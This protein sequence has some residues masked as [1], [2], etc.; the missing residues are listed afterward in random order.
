MHLP[1]FVLLLA[2]PLSCLA[3]AWP[4]KTVRFVVPSS[5]GASTDFT[6]RLI[7][8]RVSS[9]WKQQVV[10]EN[11]AG[12]NFIVGTDYVSKQ[13]PDGYTLLFSTMGGTALNPAIFPN[14]PYKF[15][16]LI[17]V[18][19]AAKNNMVLYVNHA[20]PAKNARE[21]LAALK[22][23][24]GKYNHASGGTSTYMISQL[25]RSQTG[26]EFVDINYKGGAPALASLMAGDTHF[27][28]ADTNTADA[29]MRSGR[30][31]ML[32]AVAPVRSRMLPDLPSLPEQG[33]DVTFTSGLGIFAPKGT[34][35]EIVRKINADVQPLTKLP[36]VVAALEKTGSEAESG[37]VEDFQRLVRSEYQLWSKLTKARNIKVPE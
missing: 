9:V 21:F 4:A 30:V 26:V 32:G 13:P 28:F 10:I 8:S 35:M 22:A 19:Q 27:S 33:M 20:F 23:N 34:P 17:P 37:S 1:T 29:A 31:R 2:L 16:D 12:A 25:L 14:L 5:P 11:R 24:P 7:A 3:Q 36:E 15:D 18:V 6:A